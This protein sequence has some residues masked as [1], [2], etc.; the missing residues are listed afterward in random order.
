MND[1]EINLV[2][3]NVYTLSSVKPSSSLSNEQDDLKF[4]STVKYHVAH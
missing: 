3:T 1:D 4:A 2:P